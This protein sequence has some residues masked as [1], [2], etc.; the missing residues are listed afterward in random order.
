MSGDP[1]WTRDCAFLLR[2]SCQ[3]SW[4]KQ[5]NDKLSREICNWPL[6][7]PPLLS[8]KSIVASF[9]FPGIA[10]YENDVLP[11]EGRLSVLRTNWFQICDGILDLRCQSHFEM[12]LQSHFYRTHFSHLM[13]NWFCEG[14]L[15]KCILDEGTLCRTAL[16]SFQFNFS[17]VRMCK[18]PF[19]LIAYMTCIAWNWASLS[20]RPDRRVIS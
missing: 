12:T 10:T 16:P 14:I 2:P 20:R 17:V 8:S 1:D 19:L 4:S 9:H 11:A 18:L 6:E 15:V 5:S 3:A 13:S 7:V